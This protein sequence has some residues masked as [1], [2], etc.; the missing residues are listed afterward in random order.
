M[1]STPRVV[2]EL[3]RP[4]TPD[5]TAARKAASSRAYRS[6]Q[7]FR[8]LLVAL[9][10]TL[11][12]VAIVIFG[13]PRGSLPGQESVDVAAAAEAAQAGLGR[14]FLAPEVPEGWRANTARMER[15]AWV[16]V[17][18]PDVFDS[19]QGFVRLTQAPADDERWV[20]ETVGGFAPTG[21]VAIDG[22]VWDEYDVATSR[23]TEVTYGLS[24]RVGGDIVVLAG[25]T[26]ADDAA[27]IAAALA[28]DIRAL[29]RGN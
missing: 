24:T 22:V 5:E 27:L 1:A 21:T 13:V 6:S 9:G 23:G 16:V 28:D 29:Q 14:T 12:V 19:D 7:T 3:G 2:A 11:V 25:P 15:A 10:V 26:T 20:T 17:F 4:E 18:T 8:N